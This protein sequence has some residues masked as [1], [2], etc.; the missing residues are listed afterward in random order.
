MRTEI[1]ICSSRYQSA[2]NFVFAVSWLV[3]GCCD[4]IASLV[5][6]VSKLGVHIGLRLQV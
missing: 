4:S 1:R 2:A 3:E 5:L 6:I